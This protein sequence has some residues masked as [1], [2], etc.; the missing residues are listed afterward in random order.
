MDLQ[1][2]NKVVL[3]SGSPPGYHGVGLRRTSLDI[4]LGRVCGVDRSA[5]WNAHVWRVCPAQRASAQIRLCS[6][7]NCCGCESTACAQSSCVEI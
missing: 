3:V 7:S 1:L 5:D 4:W 2:T 6:R